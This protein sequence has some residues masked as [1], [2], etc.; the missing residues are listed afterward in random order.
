MYQKQAA[1]EMKKHENRV[2]DE[3][4]RH[5]RALHNLRTKYRQQNEVI[6]G[7]VAYLRGKR[8]DRRGCGLRGCMVASSAGLFCMF[9]I[10]VM[11]LLLPWVV[12]DDTE[13]VMR[14]EMGEPPATPH[15]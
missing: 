12:T 10:G 5:E 1:L 7:R 15:L 6:D 13:S 3:H 11:A 14:M 2:G 9:L 4:A 8:L